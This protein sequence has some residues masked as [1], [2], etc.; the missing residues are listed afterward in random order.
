LLKL[1]NV[2]NLHKLHHKLTAFVFSSAQLKFYTG[3]YL[4]RNRNF[5]RDLISQKTRTAKIIKLR[6]NN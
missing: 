3:L 2:Y 4:K 5:T 6:N 1:V